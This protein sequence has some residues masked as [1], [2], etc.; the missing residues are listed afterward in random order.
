VGV[1]V[2]FVWTLGPVRIHAKLAVVAPG[3][4][5]SWTG[6]AL[7]TRAVDRN[8]L[9]ERADGTSRLEFEESLSGVGVSLLYRRNR[10][11][12]QHDVWLSAVKA[13][14]EAR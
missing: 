8:V 11:R 9:T 2:P 1:D 5:L 3:R 10:L 12:R 7:W 14:A 13:A 6:A 4:E